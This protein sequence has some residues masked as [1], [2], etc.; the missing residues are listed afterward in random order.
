[1]GFLFGVERFQADTRRLNL[2]FQKEIKMKKRYIV[3]GAVLVVIFFLVALVAFQAGKESSKA[4]SALGIDIPV[5]TVLPVYNGQPSV[6]TALMP[7]ASEL[8]SDRA[9]QFEPDV[10]AGF[11]CHFEPLPIDKKFGILISPEKMSVCL[12]D[13]YYFGSEVTG[14]MV[15]IRNSGNNV[16]ILTPVWNTCTDPASGRTF[17]CT[18]GA[19]IDEEYSKI[20]VADANLKKRILQEAHVKIGSFVYYTPVRW[21]PY[22][23]GSGKG[24]WQRIV[25]LNMIVP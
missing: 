8:T 19:T 7:G 4:V 3:L 24:I 10:P 17:R 11:V 5:R 12:L 18:K 23:D 15:R 25:D 13:D 14:G 9:N 6:P 21:V 1:M 22:S 20:E 16:F 2:L